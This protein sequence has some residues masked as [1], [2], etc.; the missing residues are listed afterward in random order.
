M[1]DSGKPWKEGALWNL[2]VKGP[3]SEK[4]M[5]H[6]FNLMKMNV[7]RGIEKLTHLSTA[8][9]ANVVQNTNHYLYQAYSRVQRK[10]E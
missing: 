1:G 10:L 9:Q 4:D 5:E 2:V 8:H 7:F 6:Y 3:S